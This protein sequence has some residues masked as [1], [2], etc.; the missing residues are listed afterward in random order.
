MALTATAT[1]GFIPYRQVAAGEVLY[2]PG[3]PGVTYE[4]GNTLTA[5]PGAAG[6]GVV[7]EAA[8]SSANVCGVVAQT[9]VCPAASQGFPIPG[10]T[11]PRLR[12]A[13]NLTL[14]PMKPKVPAGTQVY[15]ATFANHK[16]DTV[17]TYTAATRAIACTT[18]FAADD[19]PNGGLLYVYEG[20]GA[21][22]VNLV[23]D[24]DHT[25]GA[26]ELLLI[27][28]RAFATALDSTSKFIVVSGEAV[29]DYGIGFFSRMDAD[30]VSALDASDGANDGDWVVYMDWREAGEFLKN[31]TLPVVPREVIYSA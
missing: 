4:R 24:Y 20:T 22:Q 3:D 17:I 14:I 19:Y 21:G 15:K 26:A 29:A 1:Q 31:L 27:C 28:H 13:S 16:D 7:T 10:A 23:E 30:T 11:L 18:G 9:T 6:G 25:G 2:V 8:D 5:L 12:D